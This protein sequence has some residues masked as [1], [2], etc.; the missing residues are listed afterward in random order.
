[1]LVVSLAGAFS[2]LLRLKGGKGAGMQLRFVASMFL[3]VAV[4]NPLINHHGVTLLGMFLNQ[5]ITLE[6]I[7]LRHHG[8][9]VPGS[10]DSLVWLLQ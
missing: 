9:P 3:L 2:F 8:G 7:G 5:W 1:M 10:I 6:A 4:A